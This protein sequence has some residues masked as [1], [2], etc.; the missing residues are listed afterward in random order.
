M[1]K[2]ILVPLDGS[3]TADHGLDEAIGLARD[4]HGTLCLLHIIDTFPMMVEWTTTATFEKVVEDLRRYGQQLLDKAA[5]RAR[6]QGV[7]TE[8][9]VL[10]L[11]SERVATAIVDQAKKLQC[12]LIVMGTH[13][14]KGVS[15][16]VLGSA[17]EG[18]IREA[19]VPVLLVR[20]P[21]AGAA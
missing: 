3:E 11:V 2:R 7:A 6:D 14:R 21:K 1:Y 4:G 13:G 20:L 12:D 16:L 10:E 15:H 19:E 17:A 18:V 8:S 5:A 9:V